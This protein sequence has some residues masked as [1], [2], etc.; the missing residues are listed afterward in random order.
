[1]RFTSTARPSLTPLGHRLLHLSESK[2]ANLEPGLGGRDT[3]STLW[4]GVVVREA[5]KS[6]WKSVDQGSLGEMNDWHSKSAMGL[7]V[8]GED[9][10]EEEVGVAQEERWFENLMSSFGDDDVDQ[11]AQAPHE[12]IESNVAGAFD[13]IDNVEYYDEDMEAYTLPTRSPITSPTNLP[14]SLPAYEAVSYDEVQ[15]RVEVSPAADLDDDV[16]VAFVDN[17]LLVEQ[18]A[19][20]VLAAL[21]QPYSAS[22]PPFG[23][24]ISPLSLSPISDDLDQYAQDFLLPPPLVRSLSSSSSSLEDDDDPCVT[25]PTYSYEELEDEDRPVDDGFAMT[26]KAF[27]T[28][29]LELRLDDETAM[30]V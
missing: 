26:K 19:Q 16:Q 29:W 1:M 17:V 21:A 27:G 28:G 18:P 20:P 4:K 22:H 3:A 14:A 25:P 23:S 13:D 6:A 5:V 15:V 12:W 9:E 24:P 7:D 10:E 30:V 8:I 11:E 2:L